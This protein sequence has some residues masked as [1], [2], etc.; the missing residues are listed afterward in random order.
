MNK[1]RT[2]LLAC[3]AVFSVL[4]VLFL[5]FTSPTAHLALSL[6][7]G[8]AC[9][10]APVAMPE[11]EF[12]SKVLKSVE[13]TH[14]E[15]GRFKTDQ[16][17][18]LDDYT[19]TDKEVKK[20]A[21]DLQK[22][23][24]TCNEQA[25]TIQ[26]L[27]KLQDAVMKNA[28]SSFGD[29]VKRCLANDET[30]EFFTIIGEC[31]RAKAAGNSVSAALQKRFDDFRAIAQK[32]LTGVDAGLGQATVPTQ[33]FNEIYDTLLEYGQWSTL[34]VMR[35]GMRTVILPVAT[36]RPQFYW[37]GS[38]TGGTGEGSVI[39]AGSFGGSSVTL[40]IQTLAAYLTVSRELL[41]DST[42]DLAPFILK[43]MTQS[44][45]QG[46]D[47]AAFIATGGADQ[48]NAGYYGIFN[49]SS[50][51]TNCAAVSAQGNT[52]VAGTQLDDWVNVLLTVNPEV[53]TR[54]AKWWMHPQMVARAML[55]RDKNGRPIFQ[56]WMERPDLKALGSILGYPIILT[57]IAP[58]TD[59]PGQQV[60][61]FGDPEG[62]AIAIREDLEIATSDDI[63]FA[64]NMRAFRTLLRAGVKTKTT[65][66]STTLIPFANLNLSPN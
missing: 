6:S 8:L 56:T 23:M 35:V 52:T 14:T 50:V 43:E 42:V 5:F 55:V 17:K 40:I 47:T 24:T 34:G 25:L 19:R 39:T 27:Q 41:A 33:T 18:I 13:D 53:L 1:R 46:L 11:A 4:A 36:S 20:A 22:V 62:Q 58:N 10:A 26:R 61:T 31:M 28:R 30:R 12:Q 32:S 45:A 9:A 63:L 59:G 49:A 64:Q 15:L 29:P 21:E 48:T 66:N 44:V 16:Q 57:G 38:G 7:K 51:N 3:G 2:L 60:A 65:A 54:A 37:V